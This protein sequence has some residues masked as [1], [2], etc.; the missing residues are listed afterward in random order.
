M[1]TDS[2]PGGFLDW[3]DE[4]ST[5]F[6]KWDRLPTELRD[7]VMVHY[8]ADLPCSYGVIDKRQHRINLDNILLALLKTQ[9]KISMQAREAYYA[10]NIFQLHCSVDEDTGKPLYGLVRP[11]DKDA[12]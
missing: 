5:I 4:P 12:R 11:R 10:N 8:L 7:L 1:A 3:L 6:H 2:P 9:T